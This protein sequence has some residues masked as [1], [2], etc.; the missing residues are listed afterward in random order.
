MTKIYEARDHI[1][2]HTGYDDPIEHHHMAAHIIVSLGT[3]LKV[4]SDQKTYVCRGIRIPSG[5]SHRID[6]KGNSVLVFLYDCTTDVAGAIRNTEVIEASACN[7]IISNYYAFEAGSGYDA[8]AGCI[9]EQLR[10]QEGEKRLSDERILNAMQHIQRRISDSITCREIAEAVCLSESRF[11]HLFRQQV[12][13]TFA[14]YLIYQRI[15]RV[16]TEILRNKSITEAALEAGFCSSS[17][18]AD[19]NRRIFGLSAGEIIKNAV[20]IKVQ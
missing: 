4:I 6:T 19:V 2:I 13:M 18:F 15:I 9:Q 1:L 17:H 20:F 10:I 3:D 8:L 5:V 16:Y 14:S 11:S 12:G 7:R